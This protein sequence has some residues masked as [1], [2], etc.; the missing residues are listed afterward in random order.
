[1][2]QLP[3]LKHFLYWFRYLISIY[4]KNNFNKRGKQVNL[5]YHDFNKMHVYEHAVLL[6]IYIFVLFLCVSHNR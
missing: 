2:K 3:V 6:S 1:M 4:K 5:L